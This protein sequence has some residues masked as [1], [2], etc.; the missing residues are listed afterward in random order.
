MQ[1]PWWQYRQWKFVADMNG[2]GAFTA[3]DISYW[4]HWLLF[5][6]GDAVVALIGPTSFGRSLDLTSASFG[7][8]TSAWISA[9]IWVIG[10]CAVVCLHGF[11][12]DTVDP[13]YRQQQRE[14][15]NAQARAQRNPGQRLTGRAAR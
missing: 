5:M 6:P 4:A 3:S 2:D 7:S 11:F 14:Q 15:R 8:A 1:A 12:L 9:A 13:T 10:I